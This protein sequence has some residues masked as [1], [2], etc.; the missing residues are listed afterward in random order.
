MRAVRRNCKVPAVQAFSPDRER[1]FTLA[2][3]TTI[4]IA[5]KRAGGLTAQA[6]SETAAS[7]PRFA[8]KRSRNLPGRGHW[9]D[10]GGQR[11]Y[12]RKT[13][14]AETAG[15]RRRRQMRGPLERGRRRTRQDQISS[16]TLGPVKLR[17]LDELRTE[18]RKPVSSA[19]PV[20]ERAN[21]S[22][23]RSSRLT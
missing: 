20:L 2:F 10:M 11:P 4:T 15:S 21:P 12:G 19:G 18:R 22:K 16:G 23:M 13:R 14:S 7:S 5:R 17:S 6:A 9:I 1:R 8:P 3:R